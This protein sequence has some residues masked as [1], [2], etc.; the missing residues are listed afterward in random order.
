MLIVAIIVFT[1]IWPSISFTKP[2]PVITD[3][4]Q[5]TIE[6]LKPMSPITD[7]DSK[8]SLISDQSEAKVAQNG[9]IEVTE[10]YAKSYIYSHESGNNSC[11]IEGGA[12]NCNYSGTLACGLGQASPC[13]KLVAVCNLTD[14]SCEDNWFN[15]YAQTRYGGWIPAYYHWIVSHNW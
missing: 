10:Q 5:I 9:S 7:D 11:K 13:N 4:R 15:G 12:I 6:Q 2:N 3:T 8:V 14:Y 1:T